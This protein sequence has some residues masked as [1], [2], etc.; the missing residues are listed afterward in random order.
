MSEMLVYNRKTPEGFERVLVQD[1]YVCRNCPRA[2]SVRC[3]LVGLIDGKSPRDEDV[4]RCVSA[5]VFHSNVF[6]PGHQI[7]FMLSLTP[8]EDVQFGPDK[9]NHAPEVLESAAR[10]L[11]EIRISAGPQ[12]LASLF[13]RRDG[14]SADDALQ[15]AQAILFEDHEAFS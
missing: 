1:T 2:L 4:E 8:E 9:E 14:M 6:I 3:P 12:R 7:E 5:R 10:R 11:R 15:M 13:I